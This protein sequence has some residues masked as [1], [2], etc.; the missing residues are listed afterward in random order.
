MK[1]KTLVTALSAA[2]LGLALASAPVA[3]APT[4]YSPFTVFHDDDLDYVYDLDNSKT[5][6]TGDR[7]VSVLNFANTQGTFG[8]QGPSFFAPG[9]VTAVA[10]VTIATTVGSRFVFAPTNM[11]GTEG[12][13]G[14]MTAGTAAA[15]YYN[16]TPAAAD[17]LDVINSNCGTRASCIAKAQSGLLYMTAG[18][19][20][21]LDDLWVSDPIGLGASIPVV[22]GGQASASFGSFNFSLEIGVNN[23][24]RTFNQL[25]C[26]PFCGAGGDGF[27]Q[28]SGNGQIL[29]GINLVH[30]QWTAR[31]KADVTV[32]PVPEPASMALMG[33]ALAGLGV[34]RRRKFQ[35]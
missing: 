23:T 28:V 32:A 3:A 21:D 15:M 26:A 22:E 20:G 18:F 6:S 2:G 14:G 16:A 35:K 5:I 10:D 25:A 34:A 11:T 17:D 24:G 1:L 12:L 29:G 7:L 30:S 4:F 31:S 13:L 33:L 8:G 9:Q 27:V 19:F